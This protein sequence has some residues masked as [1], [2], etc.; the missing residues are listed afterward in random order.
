MSVIVVFLRPLGLRL[1]SAV[2]IKWVDAYC[3][4][5]KNSLQFA[6]IL[7][8]PPRP[9]I[10]LDVFSNTYTEPADKSD[11]SHVVL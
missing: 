1:I 8:F 11:R 6:A 2:V 9:T 4:L 5:P 3:L 10:Q 7:W